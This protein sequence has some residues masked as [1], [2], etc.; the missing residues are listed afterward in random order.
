MLAACFG[1]AFA[2]CTNVWYGAQHE[3]ER[4]ALRRPTDI[5]YPYAYGLPTWRLDPTFRLTPFAAWLE[6]QSD[7][8]EWTTPLIARALGCQEHTVR[9]WLRGHVLAPNAQHQLQLARMAAVPAG[10]G[11]AKEA[12]SLPPPRVRPERAA[13]PPAGPPVIAEAQAVLAL[14]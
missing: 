12:A 5:P 10:E 11:A 4:M 2:L 1:A 6:A 3:E 14:V 8:H 7:R 9:G 13:L